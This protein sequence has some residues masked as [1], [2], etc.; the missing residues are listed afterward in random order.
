MAKTPL[1]FIRISILLV[2]GLVVAYWI[3]VNYDYD[4][5]IT[6]VLIGI[7]TIVVY[8]YTRDIFNGGK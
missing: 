1:K 2:I 5:G 8:K 7:G 4:A 6:F 3:H